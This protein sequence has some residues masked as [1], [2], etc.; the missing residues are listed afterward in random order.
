MGRHRFFWDPFRSDAGHLERSVAAPP[1]QALQCHGPARPDFV[2]G[3]TAPG[4]W[5]DQGSFARASSNQVIW[6]G[7]D[8]RGCGITRVRLF[9]A[10]RPTA[11]TPN[12]GG[13]LKSGSLE[14]T[15]RTAPRRNSR[16]GP[17]FARI[18]S[19]MVASGRACR[20]LSAA[21]AVASS[22]KYL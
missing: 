14:K 3:R 16:R 21:V 7:N 18:D 12:S 20:A 9:R 1:Q 11:F 2:E 15:V 5:E 13:C 10:A 22:G 17:G 6:Q 4:S 19:P 8:P